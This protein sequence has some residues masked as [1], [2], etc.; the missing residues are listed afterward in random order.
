MHTCTP[1]SGISSTNT[2]GNIHEGGAARGI[3]RLSSPHHPFLGFPGGSDSKE[4][5]CNVGYLGL[6]PELGRAPGGDHGD[7]LQCSC[8]ENP[9]DREPSGLQSLGLQKSQTRLSD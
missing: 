2:S 6:I 3:R 8:L 4:S 1:I 7:P 9:L 5:A